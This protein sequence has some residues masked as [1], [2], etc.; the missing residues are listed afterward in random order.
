MRFFDLTGKD[1]TESDGAA[2]APHIRRFVKSM[3]KIKDEDEASFAR[4]LLEFEPSPAIARARI[5]NTIAFLMRIKNRLPD[6]R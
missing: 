5:D 3:G 1:E 2:T 6:E 4:G